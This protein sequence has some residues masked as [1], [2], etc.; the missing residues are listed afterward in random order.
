MAGSLSNFAETLV[1]TWLFKTSTATRPT[2]LALAALTTAADD[3][4]IGQFSTG[5][6]AE[7]AN[8]GSYARVSCDAGTAWTVSGNSVTNANDLTW[9][10]ATGTW[11]TIVGIAICD[12]ATYDA[13]NVIAHGTL[14]AN[15]DIASGDTLVIKAGQLTITFD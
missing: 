7:V 4:S 15:K 9:P 11:G 13:G 5:S 2:T 10:T 8:S 3:A 1:A 14:A 6:G 12:S